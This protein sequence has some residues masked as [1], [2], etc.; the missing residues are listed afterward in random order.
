[1]RALLNS[2]GLTLSS[3][4]IPPLASATLALVACGTHQ[5]PP[6][7]GQTLNI[8]TWADYIAPDTVANF[9]HETG[10]KVHYTTFDTNEVLATQLLTGHTNYDIVVPSDFY[11]TRL[12]KAGAF[13]KLDKAA[14]PNIV[15]L[16][17]D[18]MQKLALHDPGNQYSVPYLWSTT[19]LGYNVDKVGKRLGT[20][21]FDSWSLLLDPRNAAKLQDCGIQIIDSAT[22]VFSAVLI[23]LGKDPDSREPA[24]LEAASDALMKIRPFVRTID[25]VATIGDLANGNVCLLL[26]WSGDVTQARY[27]AIE[28][29]NGV[30]IRY[31]VPRE[32]GLIEADMMSIPADAPHPENAEKWMNYLM[33]PKVMAGITNATMYPN[34][35][36]AS[37]AFV[38]DALKNDPAIYPGLDIRSK[39]HVLPEMTPEQTRLVTR[40]WTRFRTGH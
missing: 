20:A 11:F 36:R 24:D 40:L 14:L 7:A 18:I 31:F 38:Q 2:L 8:Y 32:G 34:G 25:A 22:D 16:D 19:G 28:A 37:S 26:G 5:E 33:L 35:N 21:E 17:P 23:Y 15:N 29:S 30:K 12:M 1:M 13:R 27:R 4:I 9:E 3:A 10:I 39:L 6:A